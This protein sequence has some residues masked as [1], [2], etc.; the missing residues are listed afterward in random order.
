MD[1][2][3][4]RGRDQAGKTDNVDVLFL[5]RFENGFGGYHDAEVNHF[6]VVALQYHANDV[7]ADVMDI[8]LDRRHQDGAVASCL[9]IFFCV[10]VRQQVGDGLFHHACGFD[11]LGQ[12]HFSLTKQIT[13]HIHAVHQR[14]F[15]DMQRLLCGKSCCLGVF[16]YI[17]CYTL[18]ERMFQPF[19]DIPLAPFRVFF[20]FCGASVP[21]ILAGDFQQA[22]SGIFTAIEYDVFYTL[23]QGCG[24]IFINSQLPCINDTHVHAILDGVIQEHGMNGFAYRVVATK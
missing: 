10:H 12:E 9:A 24:N 13:D 1:H 14:T 18:D 8:A 2:F 4:Q 23:T 6:I 15:D 20:N 16:F 17:I 19:V 22:F 21:R 11:H 3:I 7:F 5:C